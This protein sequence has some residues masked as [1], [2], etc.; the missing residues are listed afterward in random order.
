MAAHTFFTNDWELSETET[1]Q[2]NHLQKLL[3]IS[4]EDATAIQ[5]ETRKMIVFDELNKIKE[6][7]RITEEEW[8][9]FSEILKKMKV[10]LDYDDQTKSIIAKY[11]LYHKLETEELKPV[12]VYINLQKNEQCYCTSDNVN[13]YETRKTR[14]RVNYAGPTYRIKL[15]K[16]LYYR[17]GSLNVAPNYKEEYVL[18]DTGALYITNKRIIFTGS[19]NNKTISL[20]SVLSL[21]PYTD[22]VEI[23][24]SGKSPI[25]TGME[26]VEM[27][28]IILSKLLSN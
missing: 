26:D 1:N 27:V 20:S 12:P 23:E 10:S 28:M 11:K 6:D 17:V 7:K 18:I 19:R 22:G 4:N 2:L 25:L 3:R 15:A 5:D 14:I 16:G 8:N 21:T 24:K 9:N 13:W